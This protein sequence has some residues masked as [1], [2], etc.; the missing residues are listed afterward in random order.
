MTKAET[1][2]LRVGYDISKVLGVP[3]GIGRYSEL[4]LG[5]LLSRD[6]GSQFTLCDLTSE[7]LDA[8]RVDEFFGA[9]RDRFSVAVDWATSGLD[10][11]IFH[12]PAPALPPTECR[13]LVFTLHDVT[14]ISHPEC[15]TLD[16]RVIRTHLD[17]PR[18]MSR[19]TDHRRVASCQG[20]KQSSTSD[21]QRSRSR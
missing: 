14:F 15:H 1:G 18:S 10:V 16:N 6:D 11:D 21:C 2:P 5:E 13:P 12:S 9:N 20:P 17:R 3:D 8:A 7:T 19:C 4:L